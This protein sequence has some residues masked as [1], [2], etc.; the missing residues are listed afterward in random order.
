MSWS[1]SLLVCHIHNTLITLTGGRRLARILILN[2]RTHTGICWVRFRAI[3]FNAFSMYVKMTNIIGV[4]YELYRL[5][6]TI[7]SLRVFA[8]MC[9]MCACYVRCL[10]STLANFKCT[11]DVCYGLWRYGRWR[12]CHGNSGNHITWSA[13]VSKV[14][15]KEVLMAECLANVNQ[16]NDVRRNENK[17]SQLLKTPQNIDNTRI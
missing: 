12:A 8:L 15:V 11:N 14:S 3:A 9:N 1:R 5:L 10:P 2:V 16:R 17:R 13:I 7:Y 6:E 4:L